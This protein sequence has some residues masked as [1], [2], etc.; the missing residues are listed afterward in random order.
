MS[1]SGFERRL[2]KIEQRL[3]RRLAV[4]TPPD[5]PEPTPMPEP[6]T[7]PA[8]DNFVARM[9]ASLSDDGQHNKPAGQQ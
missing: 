7:N 8:W 4:Y 2:E 5:E 9:E 1:S 3:L 6:G